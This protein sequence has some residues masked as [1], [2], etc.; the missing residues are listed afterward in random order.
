MKISI[1]TSNIELEEVERIKTEAVIAGHAVSIVDFSNFHYS[2]V[3]GKVSFFP[4]IP[5]TDIAIIRGMFSAMRS[6]E[7]LGQ[8]L[9]SRGIKVFDNNL[10]SHRYSINKVFDI[11]KLIFS[12]VSVPDYYHSRTYRGLFDYAK[13]MKYPAIVKTAGTGKGVAIYMIKNEK[14][15]IKALKDRQEEKIRPRKIVIQNFIDYKYDLRVLVIG[16]KMYCMRRIPKVGDFRANFSLGGSVE[17][18]PITPEIKDLA[19]CAIKSVGLEVAGVDVLI[20]K[21]GKLYILEVNHT[22]GMIGME[23]A[24][25][26]NISKIYLDYAIAHAKKLI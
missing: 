18:F 19:R 2:Y 8:Y 11:T 20:D 9:K 24:T 5:D 1:I 12:G 13:T 4:E 10:F 21:K 25:G 16:E 23:K 6:V 26:E 3:E 15:M 14:E 7:P 17:L 22:P